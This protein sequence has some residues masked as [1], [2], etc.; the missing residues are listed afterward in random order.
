MFFLNNKLLTFEVFKKKRE[1][2]WKFIFVR[3][4]QNQGVFVFVSIPLLGRMKHINSE[5]NYN[6]F[7]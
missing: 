3:T 2:R 7:I 4:R 6:I 5:Q 1:G